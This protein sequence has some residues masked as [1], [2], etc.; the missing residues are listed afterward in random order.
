MLASASVPLPAPL[1]P[2]AA[3]IPAWARLTP[4]EL[5]VSTLYGRVPGR[6]RPTLSGR[7]SLRDAMEQELIAALLRPPCVISF[8]GGRDSSTLLAIAQQLA[9]KEGLEPPIAL[10]DR[11]PYAPE[12]LEDDWQRQVIEH[13]GCK[14]WEIIDHQRGDH[15]LLGDDAL[16][17]LERYGPLYPTNWVTFEGAARLASGGTLLTGYGGDELFA[18]ALRPYYAALRNRTRPALRRTHTLPGEVLPRWARAR[19]LR[20]S[21]TPARVAWLRPATRRRMMRAEAEDLSRVPWD[22]GTMIRGVHTDRDYQAAIESV[23]VLGRATGTRIAHPFAAPRVLAAAAERYGTRH[24]RSRTAGLRDLVGD[25]LPDPVLRRSSK[26]DFTDVTL[27]PTS[28]ERLRDW[29]GE[30]IDEQRIDRA[31][32]MAEILGDQPSAQGFVA[33]LAGW[34]THH[35]RAR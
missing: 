6:L 26:A 23:A 17:W 20:R 7:L 3:E 21:T 22:Y 19:V 25:L 9:K 24:P 34:F 11:Y 30:G 33:I 32:L 8:S 18:P 5:C 2:A 10:T 4:D 31:A 29:G 35:A 28:L 13:V 15:E 27:G 1:D 16:R 14:R 12:S